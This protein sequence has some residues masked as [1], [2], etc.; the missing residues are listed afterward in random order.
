MY[1]FSGILDLNLK[2]AL[3]M[4]VVLVVVWLSL[5]FDEEMRDEGAEEAGDEIEG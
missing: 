2:S 1:D 3:K 5:M 4:A